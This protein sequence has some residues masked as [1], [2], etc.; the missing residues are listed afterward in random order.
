[1]QNRLRE[2]KVCPG[3]TSQAAEKLGV[4]GEIGEKHPSG[5]KAHVHFAALTARLK[6][7]PDAYGSSDKSFS[8]A[9]S[10]VPQMAN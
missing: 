8:A 3:T 9:C 7:C 10:V 4:S 5:A 1:M 6:S 2:I